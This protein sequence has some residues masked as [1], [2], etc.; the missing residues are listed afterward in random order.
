MDKLSLAVAEAETCGCKCGIA[1]WSNNCH[2]ILTR[3]H[4][5]IEYETTAA[6]HEAFKS[7]WERAYGGFPDMKKA[8]KY[9]G[10][11]VGA[12]NWIKNVSKAYNR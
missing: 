4:K 3:E 10:W 8:R 6:S 7:L 5:V 12:C 9:V 1:T 11:D 2:G